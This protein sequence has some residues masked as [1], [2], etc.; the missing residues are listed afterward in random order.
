MK[1]Y[2][3]AVKCATNRSVVSKFTSFLTTPVTRGRVIKDAQILQPLHALN[4]NKINI[5]EEI[6]GGEGARRRGENCENWK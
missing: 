4:N 1:R 6:R 5:P 2:L 3:S